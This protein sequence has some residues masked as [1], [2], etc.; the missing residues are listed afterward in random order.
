M[1]S[2]GALPLAFLVALAPSACTY[3]PEER[4][5]TVSQVVRLGDSYRA[6]VVARYASFQRPTGLRAFP[7]GG[8]WRYLQPLRES[9]ATSGSARFA[10]R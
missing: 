8:K 6:I 10:M 5:A 2:V 3:G 4:S 1:R 9:E 7:D